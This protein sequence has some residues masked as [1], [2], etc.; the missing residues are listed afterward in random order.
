MGLRSW[1]PGERDLHDLRVRLP[2]ADNPVVRPDRSAHPLPLLGHLGVGFQDQR[3]HAGQ[4]LPAPSPQ[5]AD[6]LVDEPGSGF[7]GR[8]LTAAHVFSFTEGTFSIF[9]KCCS[10]A[11]TCFDQ[12]RRK[13]TSHASRSMS[14]SGLSRYRRRC[15]SI[16]CST[17][18]ASRSTR[19]CLETDGCDSR[20][21]CRSPSPRSSA[22]CRPAFA[23]QR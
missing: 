15:A 7:P 11:S 14:D 21:S 4:G 1:P 10:R 6:P 23:G 19:R 13:G 5:V 17:N 18:P 8:S 9:S 22:N 20:S 2:G 3:P 16:R 12:K